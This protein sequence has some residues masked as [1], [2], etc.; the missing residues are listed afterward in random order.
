MLGRSSWREGG[1]IDRDRLDRN[2]GDGEE[3][4]GG[5]S[6]RWE[7]RGNHRPSHDSSHHPPPRTARAWE[8]NHHDN[9]DN[10]PEWLILNFIMASLFFFLF[11]ISSLNLDISGRRKIRVKAAAVSML[12][13]RFMVECIQTTMKT[14]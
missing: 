2:D 5:G 14:V 6:G 7:H 13:A 10:L 11:F 3:S 12:Q 1:S 8:S 4:R 9:H